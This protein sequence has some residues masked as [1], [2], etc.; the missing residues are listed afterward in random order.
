[1]ANDNS[2]EIYEI[3]KKID[4]I[5]KQ[6]ISNLKDKEVKVN[7]DIPEKE[8]ENLEKRNLMPPI[9]EAENFRKVRN[10]KMAKESL[11]DCTN[12]KLREYYNKVIEEGKKAV[13]TLF[14]VFKPSAFN[15]GKSWIHNDV[16]NKFE[17][18]QQ[19]ILMAL[20]EAILDY[21]LSKQVQFNTYLNIIVKKNCKENKCK[22]T[23]FSTN[24]SAMQKWRTVRKHQ[25]SMVQEGYDANDLEELAKRLNRDISTPLKRKNFID[26]L[27]DIKQIGVQSVSTETKADE[28]SR[29]IG[30]T[31][32]ADTLDPYEECEKEWAKK[33]FIKFFTKL[34]KIA[35]EAF[36]LKFLNCSRTEK[37]ALSNEHKTALKKL[38]TSNELNRILKENFAKGN[39]LIEVIEINHLV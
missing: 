34:P 35:R 12:E 10:M 3:A 30:E 19:I 5:V 29:T 37:V 13:E 22:S 24:A 6:E 11:K 4:K 21:D 25:E 32:V 16:V 39:N 20:W 2:I 36:Y 33:E 27:E 26:M 15:F 18:W 28:E 23:T 8:K 14:E 38:G 7:L 9:R 17:D 31:L 1:M